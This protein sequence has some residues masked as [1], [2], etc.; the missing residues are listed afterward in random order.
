MGEGERLRMHEEEKGREKVR[1]RKENGKG[2]RNEKGEGVKGE[3]VGR[4]K[5]DKSRER[6]G[7]K[8]RKKAR[9]RREERRK[10]RRE[11]RRRKRPEKKQDKGGSEGEE[12][13]E[14][15]TK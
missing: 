12:E 8:T 5:T 9:Q 2:G 11:R 4:L 15:E 14:G 10:R 1:T 3:I 13:S 6:T 7:K